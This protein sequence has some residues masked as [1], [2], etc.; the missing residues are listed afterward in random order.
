MTHNER[1]LLNFIEVSAM[2][3]LNEVYRFLFGTRETDL[4]QRWEQ[5]YTNSIVDSEDWNREDT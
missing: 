4:L 3:A 2:N 5:N 1:K